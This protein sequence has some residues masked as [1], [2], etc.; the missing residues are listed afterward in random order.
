VNVFLNSKQLTETTT[1]VH[2]SAKTIATNADDTH[3]TH[4]LNK[5][6]G[7]ILIY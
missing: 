1:H 4:A 5:I 2:L 3:H 7:F 6:V